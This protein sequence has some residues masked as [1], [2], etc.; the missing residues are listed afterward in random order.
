MSEPGQNS[1]LALTVAGDLLKLGLNHGG[2][3]TLLEAQ[4]RS[5]AAVEIP[6]LERNRVKI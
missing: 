4:T 3:T 5:V 2:P 1:Q 6:S